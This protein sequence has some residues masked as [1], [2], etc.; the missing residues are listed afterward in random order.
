[1]ETVTSQEVAYF[2][3]WLWNTKC[4]SS[5]KGRE[6]L[7][8]NGLKKQYWKIVAISRYDCTKHSPL[9]VVTWFNSSTL[10]VYLLC[11]FSIMPSHLCVKSIPLFTSI[12]NGETDFLSCKKS[13][14][15]DKNYGI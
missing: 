9:N 13:T 10:S 3:A 7:T 2:W 15:E 4:L 14:L 5:S 8:S 6:H 1:M 11:P 12:Q